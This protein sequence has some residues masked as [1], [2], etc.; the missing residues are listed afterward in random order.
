[1]SDD[2][3]PLR[4]DER[5]KLARDLAETGIEK[6]TAVKEPVAIFTAGQSGSGKSMIVNSMRI[7]FEGVG[8]A[9]EIDPDK[10]RPQIPY[11]RD[12]IER[13]DLDIPQVAFSDAGNLAH[14]VMQISAEERR[15]I[16]YDGTLSN[17][18]NSSKSMDELKD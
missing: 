7:E 5:E 8:G 4:D 10:I 18:G 14:R 1:M 11:M 3:K 12:R 16:I 9:V 2:Q 13:G 6:S 17:Y 15:N